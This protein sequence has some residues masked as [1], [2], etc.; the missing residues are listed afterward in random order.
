MT[1]LGSTMMLQVVTGL[2]DATEVAGVPLVDTGSTH[3]FIHSE[4]VAHLGLPVTPRAGL[5][6]LVANGDRVRS[7]GVCLAIDVAILDE[8]FAIDCF[9]LNLA[10]ACPPSRPSHPPRA[11]LPS[12]GGAAVPLP[13][14]PQG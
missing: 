10:P 1:G 14:A 7:P 2:V 13:P 12:G 3:T 11:Q 8:H 4:V 6:V 9:A 5:S